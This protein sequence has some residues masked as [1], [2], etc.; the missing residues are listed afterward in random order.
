MKPQPTK[1]YKYLAPGRIDN[2]IPENGP[3]TLRLSPSSALND[4]F[5][6]MPGLDDFVSDI[7]LAKVVNKMKVEFPD[8]TNMEHMG[9][10]ELRQRRFRRGFNSQYR[11][12]FDS[13]LGFVSLSTTPTNT[14]MW[15]HYAS[16]FTGFV[17]GYAFDAVEA[18]VPDD[19]SGTLAEV[20]YQDNRPRWATVDDFERLQSI[21][22]NIIK[23]YTTKSKTWEYENEWRLILP[24]ST[25]PT[26]G[27][28]RLV[29]IPR[30]AVCEVIVSEFTDDDL[31]ARLTARAA[32]YPSATMMRVTPSQRTFECNIEE[33]SE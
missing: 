9:Q 11:D 24:I 6:V 4:P 12:I 16:S 7:L 1:L 26:P 18:L 14:L 10:R 13:M 23:C 30:S 25:P 22:A 5:E 19:L 20:Q 32:T 2:A 29:E 21:N 27:G 8:D 17:V 3:S 28:V 33:M 15:A 31:V